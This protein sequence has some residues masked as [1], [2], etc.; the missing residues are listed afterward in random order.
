MSHTSRTGHNS[1]AGLALLIGLLLAAAGAIATATATA[2]A[3]ETATD[4]PLVPGEDG[5]TLPQKIRNV[6]PDYP[7]G[8]S[9]TRTEGAVRL[10]FV[11]RRDGNVDA[12]EVIDSSNPGNGFEEAARKAVRNWRYAPAMRAGKPV[13]VTLEISVEFSPEE[14]L[15][16]KRWHQI[17]EGL[18]AYARAEIFREGAHVAG[19]D[20]VS[21]PV[22]TEQKKAVY[23]HGARIRGVNSSVVL[24]A[25]IDENGDVADIPLSHSQNNDFPFKEAAMDSVRGWHFRPATLEGKPVAAY[26]WIRIHFPTR[27]G[28]P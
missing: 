9:R 17:E 19:E 28:R 25:L 14:V 2:T 1:A 16:Q 4:V 20:G 10:R 22:A 15:E 27:A 18:R 24:L 21:W 5:V 13:D 26:H 3:T 12:V 23:P 7:M 8:A 6:L 11:V